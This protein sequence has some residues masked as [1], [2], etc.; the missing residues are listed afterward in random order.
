MLQGDFRLHFG[1]GQTKK[2]DS[3]EI[4]WPGG[5]AQLLENI[6]AR[7]IITIKEGVGIVMQR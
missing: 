6:H 7:E 5:M 4:R 3:L 2:V 1:L